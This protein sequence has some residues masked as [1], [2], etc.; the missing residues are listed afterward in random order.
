[1]AHGLQIFFPTRLFANILDDSVHVE[2]GSGWA[3]AWMLVPRFYRHN[4]LALPLCAADLAQPGRQADQDQ[5]SICDV[6][7]PSGLQVLV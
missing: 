4:K 7:I 3:F 5:H 6:A 1:M 2:A